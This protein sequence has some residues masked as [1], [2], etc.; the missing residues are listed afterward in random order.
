[1]DPDGRAIR[2]AMLSDASHPGRLPAR[3][4]KV[5]ADWL[6]EA[7]PD[8]IVWIARREAF[9]LGPQA[10][11]VVAVPERFALTGDRFDL[12]LRLWRT[13]APGWWRDYTATGTVA[14]QRGK[15]RLSAKDVQEGPKSSGAG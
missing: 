2:V 5:D 7:A 9:E 12:G 1:V 14:V 13:E 3:E 11:G 8:S 10:Y 6:L 15:I 4:P